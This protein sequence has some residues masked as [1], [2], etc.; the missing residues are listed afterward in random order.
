MSQPP[1]ID[2]HCHV[3]FDR[4][5]A[6]RGAVLERAREAGVVAI[7]NP[8]VGVT[9][10]AAVCDLAEQEP[11]IYAGVGVHPND[12]ANFDLTEIAVLRSLAERKQVVAVGE[13]GLDYYWDR[14]PKDVQARAFQA[15]LDLAAAMALPV[16]IHNREATADVVAMLADWAGGLA[17]DHPLQGRLGVLHSFSGTP[18]DAQQVADLGFYVGI[19]GPVTFKKADMLR[20]VVRV[21]PEDRLLIETDG[22]FL[23]P[24]PY[25]GKRNEPGYVQ[26]VADRIA[27]V[28]TS[29]YA[30]VATQTAANAVRLFQLSQDVMPALS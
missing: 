10:S 22:P 18:D 30:E 21:V 11:L 28:R 4:Y 24:H 29:T 20:E 9:N 7:V 19:T 27:G 6:D 15:Q 8:G 12:T 13:I 2:T 14:S 23:T 25:R 26:Y 5:D 17:A 1:L 16:I 3:D